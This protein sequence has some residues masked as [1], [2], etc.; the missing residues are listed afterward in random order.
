M[1]FYFINYFSFYAWERLHSENFLPCVI[2]DCFDIFSIRF[3]WLFASFS[4]QLI[5]FPCTTWQVITFR[6]HKNNNSQTYL[7]LFFHAKL[8]ILQLFT[9]FKFWAVLAKI[10]KIGKRILIKKKSFFDVRWPR[11]S[12]KFIISICYYLQSH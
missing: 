10:C 2:P 1:Y 5:Y 11:V 4:S 6:Y 12:S 8:T 3:I 9:T 7:V